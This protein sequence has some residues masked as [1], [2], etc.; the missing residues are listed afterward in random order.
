MPVTTMSKLE[1]ISD[2][3][4]GRLLSAEGLHVVLMSSPWDGNGIIMRNIVEGL[5]GQFHGVRFYAADYEA[6]PR[7]A[8]LFNLLSPPGLLFIRDGELIERVT[9]PMSAGSVRALLHSMA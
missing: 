5:T 2:D 8:R 6:S 1:S 4:I 9:R 7:L 3:R